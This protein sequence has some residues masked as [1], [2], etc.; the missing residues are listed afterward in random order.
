MPTIAHSRKVNSDALIEP[1]PLTSKNTKKLSKYLTEQG[2]WQDQCFIIFKHACMNIKRK[3]FV[4][5][6]H[7]NLHPNQ[8]ELVPTIISQSNLTETQNK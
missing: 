4:Y 3:S 7:N 2:V 6:A 1:R 5:L 8:A